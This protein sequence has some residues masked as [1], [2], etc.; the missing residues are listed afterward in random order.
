MGA[1]IG[2]DFTPRRNSPGTRYVGNAFWLLL[3]EVAGKAANLVFAIMV[4]R[5]LGATSYGYFTFALS[6]VPL[7]LMFGAWGLN[8]AL[9]RE[10]ARAPRRLSVLFASGLALRSALG[11]ITLTLSVLFAPLLVEGPESFV[12][13]IIIGS[14]LFVDELSSFLGAVFK[15]FERTAFHAL[16]LLANRL[17]STALAFVALSL[18][19]TLSVVSIMYLLGSVG[20]FAWGLLILKRYFPRIRLR[21]ACRSSVVDLWKQGSSIGIASFL[22]MVTFRVD[23]V[24]LQALRGPVAVAMYGVAYRFLESFLFVTWALTNVALPR[25]SR[26]PHSKESRAT[27]EVTAV[28]ILSAY[29]PLAVGAPFAAKWAV[30]T[31]FS[32]RY[33]PST[34]AVLW[35]TTAV[36]FYGL[37]HLARVACLAAGERTRITLIAAITVVVN[38]IMNVIAIPKYGFVGAAAA[39][40]ASEVL[41][42]VLLLRLSKKAGLALFKSR[43]VVAPLLASSS[44]VAVLL[45]FELRDMAAILVS[46]VVYPIALIGIA[47]L[48]CRDQLKGAVDLVR[49][50]TNPPSAVN[51]DPAI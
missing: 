18:V 14:A 39:T 6:F 33:L 8:L 4:A 35:L 48:V 27:L 22:N 3:G 2:S 12:V 28:L 30:V 34:P 25:M 7:F 1:P 42:T 49:A 41:D 9:V 15:A 40:C 24:I 38:V 20:A 26:E 45:L 31:L 11:I 37:A 21:D 19:P 17:L 46:V 50:R 43:L 36:V 44:M 10:L 51:H 23:A 29:L 16:V 5:R 32:E 47:R 13:V